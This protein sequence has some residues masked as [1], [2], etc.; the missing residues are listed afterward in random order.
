MEFINGLVRASF[1]RRRRRCLCEPGN[2][3]G[4]TPDD[5]HAV[6]KALL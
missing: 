4:K 3:P 1:R 6:Q 2:N 5:R